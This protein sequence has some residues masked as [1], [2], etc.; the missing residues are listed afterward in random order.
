MGYSFELLVNDFSAAYIRSTVERLEATMRDGWPCWAIS[1][2]DVQRALTRWGGEPAQPQL[3]KM[4]SAML[5]SLRGSVCVY[6]G[7]E[8]G[9]GEADVPFEALQDPYGITF[10]PNFK[11][12]DGCRTPMPWN[13]EDQAGFTSGNPWLPIPVEHR[14][15]A[16]QIQEA[17]SDSVLNAF[18]SF[19]AWRKL[20]PALV[21]GAIEFVDSPEPV[22]MFRRVVEG[23]TLLAAFNLSSEATSLSLPEGSWTQLDV[24]GQVSGTATGSALVLPGYA[25]F[26][27]RQS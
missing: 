19:L 18:R 8:L 13:D 5:C 10:W 23:E 2:H 27:A 3:A 11:G 17:E 21:G 4:L 9:L 6:Q 7:E 1:N 14:A 20:Q 24:P 25:V 16:V 26:F 22:L 12:R 15:H